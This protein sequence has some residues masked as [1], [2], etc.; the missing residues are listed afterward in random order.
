MINM[1]QENEKRLDLVMA[2]V[3]VMGLIASFVHAVL[4]NW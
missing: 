3:M 1:T 4:V 2:L